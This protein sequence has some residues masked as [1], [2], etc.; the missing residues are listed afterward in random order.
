MINVSNSQV[1]SMAQN[2][3]INAATSPDV[4]GWATVFRAEPCENCGEMVMLPNSF[5]VNA[6]GLSYLRSKMKITMFQFL[7]DYEADVTD[8]GDDCCTKCRHELGE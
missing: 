7:P 3:L 6:Q 8:D 4:S 2:S 1:Y 5:Q